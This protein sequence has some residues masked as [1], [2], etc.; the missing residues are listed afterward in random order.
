[1][2]RDLVTLADVPELADGAGPIRARIP[3]AK[4]GGFKDRRYGA[5]SIT[6]ADYDGW[7]RN[8][9][10]AFNG[11][12]P[13]DYDHGPEKGKSSEAAAWIKGLAL[14]TGAELKTQ[15][16]SRFAKLDDSTQY[17]VADTEWTPQGAQ[18]VRDGRWRYISPTFKAHYADETGTDRGRALIGAG[19]TNRAFLKRGMPAISLSSDDFEG[20][21]EEVSDSRG[22]MDLT[23]IAKAL[24]L[25]EDATEDKILEALDGAVILTADEHATLLSS[26]SAGETVKAERDQERY[27]TAWTK[28]LDAGR[29]APAMKDHFAKLRTLDV[30]LAV[31]TLDD[32]S[33]IVPTTARGGG[34]GPVAAAPDG[35]DADRFELHERAEAIVR[36]KGIS[37]DSD[38]GLALYRETVHTLSTEA[39]EG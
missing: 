6:R 16:P 14:H 10:D 12:V 7:H 21:A 11:E 36:E 8:L 4:L 34:G 15:D 18:A 33:P 20:P 22:T 29:V 3:V 17:V 23:K 19:L 37:L 25:A 2:D 39:Q 13:I 32:L 27:D 26:A 28:A 1:M 9:N 31:K 30:D 35:V 24:S 5:F 38:A